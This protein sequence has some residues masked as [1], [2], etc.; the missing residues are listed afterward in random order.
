MTAS[1]RSL[2]PISVICPTF[3]SE[4]FIL[5]AMSSVLSQTMLPS[6]FCI[7]DD[8]STD[9]TVKLI[10][11]FKK[12]YNGPTKI[13]LISARH[14]GPGAARNS[15]IKA[16]SQKWLAF[17]DSDDEWFSNKIETVLR[18]SVKFPKANFF[19][20]SEVQIRLDGHSSV[21]KYY[22]KWQQQK[23]LF[24]QLYM[25]NLFSTS[26]IVCSR[27][28]FDKEGLFSEKL[29]SAQDYEMWLRFSET[30][31]LCFIK[32]VLGTYIMRVGNISSS[33]FLPRMCNE[34][35]IALQYRR[36]AGSL[37][38]LRRAL[39]VVLAIMY[40]LSRAKFLK[41]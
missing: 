29:S 32:E 1:Q 6:E 16:S 27:S 7:C 17:L 8:G 31:E 19:C 9:N 38:F 33:S 2:A 12:T 20:H 3:N 41:K 21:A 13:I 11:E 25:K 5:T 24:P 4:S 34:I 22:R 39:R 14:R 36:R 10:T 40:Q 26:A 18:Y 30:M 15:A 23:P 35:S 28:L 37:L